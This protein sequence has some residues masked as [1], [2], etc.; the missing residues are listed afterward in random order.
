MRTEEGT[1]EAPASSLVPR[2]RPGDL[3]RRAVRH[4]LPIAVAC[5]AFFGVALNL[6]SLNANRYGHPAAI[7]SE[8]IKG[9]FP[10]GSGAVQGLNAA[11]GAA[12]AS[13]Q[14][15]GSQSGTSMQHGGSSMQHGAP[16]AASPTNPPSTAQA[17]SGPGHGG[18]RQS[19]L[20]MRRL[21]T[22]SGYLALVLIAVT[23]LIGPANLLLRRRTP[24]SSYVRRDIGFFAALLSVA[25][26]VFGFLVRHGDGQLLGYFFESGDRSR[27]LTS[28]FGLANWVGLLATLVVVGLAL[29]S[30]DAALRRL[31]ARRWKRLQR[32]NYLLFALVVVHAVLYGALWRKTSPYTAL[33]GITAIV[34]LAGQAVGVRLWRRRAATRP[35]PA[36]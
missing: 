4:Y 14:H 3:R 24:L 2:R 27:I 33:L 1:S 23:L 6:P 21:T 16:Q 18:N 36:S 32:L 22:T 29:I 12:G 8:G 17:S 10:T 34:V 31:K 11:P 25:H 20:R 13:M 5:A 19:A 28:S 7:F 35:A 30:T 26:V 15:G 9:A